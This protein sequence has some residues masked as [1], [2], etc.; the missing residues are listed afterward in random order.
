MSPRIVNNLWQMRPVISELEHPR[1]NQ[2][3]CLGS[4]PHSLVERK[5]IRLLHTFSSPL[6]YV[7]QVNYMHI[8]GICCT[9]S[10][11]FCDH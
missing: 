5:L 9:K 8:I 11:Q 2:D 4:L 10:R 3:Q 6:S 1:R 7:W